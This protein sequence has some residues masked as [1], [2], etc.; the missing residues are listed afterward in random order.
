MDRYI[1]L[2]NVLHLLHS[3]MK[4]TTIS[5]ERKRKLFTIMRDLTESF[6][7]PPSQKRLL[8]KE[9]DVKKVRDGGEYKS[10]RIHPRVS[11]ETHGRACAR[12][13]GQ[14]KTGPGA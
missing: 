2:L 13:K 1:F 3:V 7:F 6:L 14:L 12:R 11:G 10:T 4:L 5:L 9:K 8:G